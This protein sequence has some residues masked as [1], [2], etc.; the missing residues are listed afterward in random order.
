MLTF[1][2][3]Y[4]KRLAHKQMKEH[5]HGVPCILIIISENLKDIKCCGRI[6]GADYISDIKFIFT[7]SRI[8][9]EVLIPTQSLKFGRIVPVY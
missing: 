5:T 4:F 1:S 9:P 7:G 2:K 8:K 6:L 3:W